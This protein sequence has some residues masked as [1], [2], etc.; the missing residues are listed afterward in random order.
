MVSRKQHTQ[1]QSLQ[2]K[3]GEWV[4]CRQSASGEIKEDIPYIYPLGREH[5]KERLFQRRWKQTWEAL[6]C[7]RGT[8]N[9]VQ[10]QRTGHTL[11][12]QVN[13]SEVIQGLRTPQGDQWMQKAA[14]LEVT[15]QLGAGHSIKVPV[16]EA[17]EQHMDEKLNL[18]VD[19]M[20]VQQGPRVALSYGTLEAISS[21]D[22]CIL[23]T[24]YHVWATWVMSDR[25]DYLQLMW[26][27]KQIWLFIGCTG[28]NRAIAAVP[29]NFTVQG[30]NKLSWSLFPIPVSLWITHNW[31]LFP[32]PR[33]Q[34]N[35]RTDVIAQLTGY[36]SLEKSWGFNLVV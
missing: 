27:R 26:T 10:P 12:Q 29:E 32:F 14:P 31:K 5:A 30:E 3:G 23:K 22:H 20:A 25:K 11:L 16:Q 21:Y 19:G 2:G 13:P 8:D 15:L 36:C 6:H 24:R 35:G 17:M 7:W 1:S 34:R 9:A 4:T 28:K 18:K 33:Q